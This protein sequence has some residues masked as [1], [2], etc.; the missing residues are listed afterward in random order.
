MGDIKGWGAGELQS[1]SVH[2]VAPGGDHSD[3]LAQ[4]E[5]MG[6]KVNFGIA[7]L[8]NGYYF[9]YESAASDLTP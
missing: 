4:S 7:V 8:N 3:L 2:H 9:K 5:L 6:F 1:L